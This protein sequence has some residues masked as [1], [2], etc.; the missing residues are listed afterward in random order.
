[1]RLHRWT[2]AAFI[3][4]LLIATAGTATAARLITG[5]QI[6]DGSISANDLSKAVRAQLAKAGTPGPTGPKG[7]TGA[8]GDPSGSGGKV[9]VNDVVI[10]SSSSFQP[11]GGPSITLE[12]PEAAPGVGMVE[13]A[14]RA[15][16]SGDEKVPY[17]GLFE[18]GEPV[19]ALVCEGTTGAILKGQGTPPW[20]GIVVTAPGNTCGSTEGDLN[21]TGQGVVL[22]QTTPGQHTYTIRYSASASGNGFVIFSK[23]RLWMR[24]AAG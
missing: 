9:A 2:A 18:D 7:D 16:L 6:K 13:M 23:V 1:M 19:P 4:G 24:A 8:K 21:K 10:A 20:N 5:K 17:I 12:V 3:A 11:G 15:D 22:F 14:A